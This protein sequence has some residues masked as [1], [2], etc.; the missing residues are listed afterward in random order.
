MFVFKA[1]ENSTSWIILMHFACAEFNSETEM[2]NELMV[3]LNL[4]LAMVSKLNAR[5][6]CAH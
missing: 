6:Y 4:F 3:Y 1:V 5:N 2:N